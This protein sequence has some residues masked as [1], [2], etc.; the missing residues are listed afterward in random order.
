MQQ[1][2][3]DGKLTKEAKAIAV[4]RIYDSA[5]GTDTWHRHHFVHNLYWTDSVGYIAGQAGAF[6]LIDAIASHL[7]S[8]KRLKNEPFQVWILKKNPFYKNEE[9]EIVPSSIFSVATALDWKYGISTSR[10]D[11]ESMFFLIATD[12]GKNDND[13]LPIVRQ[14]IPYSDFPLDE[15]KLWVEESYIQGEGN[16]VLMC[17]GDR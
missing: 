5:Q 17:P 13:P 16:W 6:W 11:R 1:D 7:A 12:G 15:I 3:E 4:Q 10:E 9:I 2:Q 8:N 14:A